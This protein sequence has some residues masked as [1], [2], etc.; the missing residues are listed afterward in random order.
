MPDTQHTPTFTPDV[1][2]VIATVAPAAPTLWMNNAWT[3]CMADM[4]SEIA[5]FWATRINE[6][7]RLQQSMLKCTTLSEMQHVQAEFVQKAVAQYQA[8]TG[9]LI[10][11][12]GK[13]AAQVDEDA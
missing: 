11:L 6:D 8:E 3:Q 13:I 1:L 12:T 9:K 2:D 7:I 5:S 10:A 4:S